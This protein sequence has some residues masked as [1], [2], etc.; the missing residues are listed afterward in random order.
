MVTAQAMLPSNSDPASSNLRVALRSSSWGPVDRTIRLRR[1]RFMLAT[2]VAEQ[3]SASTKEPWEAIA[4][5]KDGGYMHEISVCVCATPHALYPVSNT[6]TGGLA[7]I[8]QGRCLQELVWRSLAPGEIPQ[9]ESELQAIVRGRTS[10]G[11]KAQAHA[12]RA[13]KQAQAQSTKVEAPAEVC[14]CVF[15]VSSCMF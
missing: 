4:L 12:Q 15:C 13:K 2:T 3:A 8:A 10:K 1:D 7:V 6:Q 11:K 14:V 9:D 5:K